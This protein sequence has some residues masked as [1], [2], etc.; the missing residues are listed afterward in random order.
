MCRFR[1]F[2]W[3]FYRCFVKEKL[4]HVYCVDVGKGLLDWKIVKNN[5]VTVIE[6]TNVRI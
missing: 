6:S 5:N 2:N 4:K 3:W 1:F